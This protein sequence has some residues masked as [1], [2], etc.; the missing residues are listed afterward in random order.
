M[1]S[2]KEVRAP[3][4]YEHVQ[5]PDMPEMPPTATDKREC[6]KKACPEPCR[7]KDRSLFGAR[8]VLS[9][10]EHGE[11]ARTPLAFFF[12]FPTWKL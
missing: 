12:N 9:V 6:S 4:E 3:V 7:R 11:R 2:E 8:S 10:R 5:S 1:A